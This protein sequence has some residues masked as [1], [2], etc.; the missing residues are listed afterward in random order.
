MMNRW[1]AA[2]LDA[3]AFVAFAV[4]GGR[5]HSAEYGIGDFAAIVGPFLI[6]WFAVALG[7]RL[8]RDPL[9]WVSVLVT[10]AGGMFVG[11][12]LRVFVFGRD[13]PLVFVAV[14]T[15]FCAVFI[16]GWRLVALLILKSRERRLVRTT[17]R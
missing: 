9:S 3:A 6:G 14:T 17:S 13:A 1:L 15:A 12:V 16:F 2:A 11:F 10:F 8:Y 7:M 5:T 4:A